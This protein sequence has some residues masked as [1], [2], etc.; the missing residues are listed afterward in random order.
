VSAT[1]LAIGIAA[2][3][4]GFGII[5]GLFGLIRQQRAAP[6]E[7][8]KSEPSPPVVS[9]DRISLAELGRTW[10]VILGVSAEATAAEIEAGY[11]ARLAECDQIRF[12]ATASDAGKHSAETRRAHVNEAYEFIRQVRH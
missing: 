6:V 4:V 11:H 8:V 12:S 7:M 10:H 2:A 5:W 9:R 3:V 1:D